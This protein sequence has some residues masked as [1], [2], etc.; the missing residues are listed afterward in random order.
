M[1]K[2]TNLLTTIVLALVIFS[3]SKSKDGSPAPASASVIGKWTFGALGIK[4]D[5]KTIEA[6]IAEIR[7]LDPETGDGL[8]KSS[9]EFKADGK[10][11]TIDDGKTE[12]GKYVIDASKKFITI[13][14]DTDIDP[15][16]KKLEITKYEIITLT[17]TNLVLGL[18]TVTQKNADGEFSSGNKEEDFINYFIG[19]IVFSAKG[20]DTDAEFEKAKTIQILIKLVK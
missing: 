2:I 14:S 17:A 19:L 3:C 9:Y 13:T 20:L 10:A 12:N 18:T 11:I 4:T 6:S 5:V 8:G 7:K 1:S 16:T 15:N